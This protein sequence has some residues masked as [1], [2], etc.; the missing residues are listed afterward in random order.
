MVK[1][2][3]NREIS[4]IFAQLWLHVEGNITI[5]LLYIRSYIKPSAVHFQVLV[6]RKVS[7]QGPYSTILFR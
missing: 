7:L 2:T 6:N 5:E 3:E 1:N 4:F